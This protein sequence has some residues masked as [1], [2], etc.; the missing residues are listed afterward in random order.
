M[1][2]SGIFDQ[3]SPNLVSLNRS[4]SKKNSLEH[5]GISFLGQKC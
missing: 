3:K 2:K 5:G 4:G 1:I